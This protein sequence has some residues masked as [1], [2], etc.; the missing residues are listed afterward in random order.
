[1]ARGKVGIFAPSQIG[2][3][4]TAMSVLR[5][6]D[7]LWPGKDIVWF[8]DDLPLLYGGS[9]YDVFKHSPISELR[10]WS[11]YNYMSL[12]VNSGVGPGMNR[13]D[14]NSIKAIPSVADLDVGYFP[15]PWQ[16]EDPM[17]RHNIPYPQISQRIFG[18]DSSL[19]WRPCLY[20]SDDER[21][22]VADMFAAL[23]HKRTVMFENSPCAYSAWNDELT[24]HVMVACRN[25]WGATNFFFASGGN[26]SGNDMSRFFDDPGCI[27]G[28]KM[29]AR[30]VALANEH[31]DL[32]V[33]VAGALTFATSYWGAKPTPKLIYT[34]CEQFGARIVANGRIEMVTT[35]AHGH[36]KDSAEADIKAKLTGLL[37]DIGGKKC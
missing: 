35:E 23:P 16:L 8:C 26:R 12:K 7:E 9:R 27:S 29:T 13:L 32:F 17:Q 33:G 25:S 2:D 6:K 36:R 37:H 5:Y 31:C 4:I 22:F 10:P 21:K 24:H 14:L 3:I 34:G 20:F 30:M 19:P 18:V 28:E 1:M 11:A 15:T